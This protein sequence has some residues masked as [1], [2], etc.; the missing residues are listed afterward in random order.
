VGVFLSFTLSQAGMA[1]HWWRVGRLAGGAADPSLQ[2]DRG[3]RW[4]LAINGLGAV[5][6]AVVTM[7]FAVTKF[8]DGAWIILLLLPTVVAA[9]FAIRRHYQHVSRD[10]S[11][12]AFGMPPR[13]QRHRVIVPINSIHQGTL[14]ALDYA[15]TLSADVTAVYIALEPAETE[16]VRRRWD[17][18]GDG[19]RLVIINSPYRAFLEP[20]LDYID[21]LTARQQAHERLT[22]VVPQFVPERWW[23]NL[24]HAQTAFWLRFALLNKRGVVIVEVP[25]QVDRQSAPRA[26]ARGRRDA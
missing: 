19:V 17:W 16:M 1:R 10:L 2:P 22:I 24:L 5:C 7:V 6:T 18:W 14:S 9:F 15:R 20:F 11:L 3:W 23:H 25:Y 13:M 8:A 12:D 21:S 4:K 26:R